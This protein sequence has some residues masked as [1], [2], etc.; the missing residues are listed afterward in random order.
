MTHI[1][2]TFYPVEETFCFTEI[3]GEPIY[4]MEFYHTDTNTVYRTLL[5]AGESLRAWLNIFA[6][7]SIHTTLSFYLK[8]SRT[9]KVVTLP[10]GVPQ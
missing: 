9:D 6:E 7:R 5:V 10:K 4:K 8:I 2:T 3:D 1:Q